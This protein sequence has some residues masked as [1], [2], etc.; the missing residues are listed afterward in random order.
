MDNGAARRRPRYIGEDTSP[1]TEKELR[2]WYSYS[3]AAEVFAVSGL[4]SFLPVTLEQL[5]RERGVLKSDGVTS[6]VAHE[7]AARHLVARADE[8]DDACVVNILGARVNTSSFALYTFSL[9]VGVQALVLISISAIADHG[10]HTPS[11][12][13]MYGM[14]GNADKKQGTTER[15]S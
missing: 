5:A 12:Y 4:G 11:N 10:G 3:I 13:R 1:T 7:T 9:A 14:L 15:D 6:C 2:G 8:A